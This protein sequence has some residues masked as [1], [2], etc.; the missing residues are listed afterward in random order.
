MPDARV[1]WLT[2]SRRPGVAST[3][4]GAGADASVDSTRI[5]FRDDGGNV[6]R[7]RA[8]GRAS[9]LA[10]DV[11]RSKYFVAGSATSGRGQL[12]GSV[13]AVQN[14][15]VAFAV[16]SPVRGGGQLFQ[17]RVVAVPRPAAV[18]VLA[19]DLAT[20]RG[21]NPLH[22]I[23]LEPPLVWSCTP[24]TLTTAYGDLCRVKCFEKKSRDFLCFR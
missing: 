2:R 11:I 6:A 24:V 3:A 22:G 9:G 4:V 1:A 10:F 12:V 20:V 14:R 18:L 21:V 17:S 16:A 19:A 13:A 23:A 8:G 7:V 15:C 5:V